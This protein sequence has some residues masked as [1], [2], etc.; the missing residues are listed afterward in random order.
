MKLYKSLYED[1]E[2]LYV[3]YSALAIILSS[4]VGAAAAM[5]ILMN[6]HDFL[7]MTQLFVVVAVAMN[8]MA[9]VLAQLKPKY[10]FNSLLVSLLVSI[11]LLFINVI[12][13][14]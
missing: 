2:K 12:M 9:S 10:V 5:V 7:Q 4:C 14:Y 13:R 11:A 3:G 1:F 6:G 8:Y